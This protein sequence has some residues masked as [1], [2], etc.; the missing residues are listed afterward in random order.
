M[1]EL[2]RKPGVF[3]R[4]QHRAHFFPGAVWQK[5]HD[6]L[7]NTLSEKRLNIEYLNLLEGEREVSSAWGRTRGCKFHH[8]RIENGK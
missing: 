5:T 1:P 8:N 4:Y 3:A 7:A 2:L 6:T